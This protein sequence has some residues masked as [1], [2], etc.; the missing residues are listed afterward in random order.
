MGGSHPFCTLDEQI[1]RLSSRGMAVDDERS[2]KAFLISHNYYR[3][4]NGYKDFFLDPEKSNDSKDV[5]RRGSSFEQLMTLFSFDSELRSRCLFALEV[6]ES[7]MKTATVYAFCDRYPETLSYLS[8]ESYCQ[9]S[10]Y[11]R[12]D[13]HQENLDSLLEVLRR[14]SLQNCHNK[15]YVQHYLDGP[16]GEVPLWVLAGCLTFGNMAH[17]FDLC[18]PSCRNGACKLIGEVVGRRLDPKRASFI[19]K[20]LKDYRNICAHGDRLF[21]AR[22]GPRRDRGFDE[23]ISRIRPVLTEGEFA[24]LVAEP[25]SD[26]LS[27]L[28]AF[29]DIEANVMI[30]MGLDGAVL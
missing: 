25:I 11:Y 4:V 9:R 24:S 12:P 19:Y 5:F 13:R 8:P 1:E 2:A 23:L 7:R 27:M 3:V 6:A 16:S 26:A 22:T 14:A 28:D 21:C 18:T 29:P 20:V 10:Q 17:F 30:E 15:P